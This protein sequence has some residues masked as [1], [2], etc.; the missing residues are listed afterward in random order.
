MIIA[1]D[2]TGDFSKNSNL[3]NI[4]IAVH[5]RSTGTILS[6]IKRRMEKW[7]Q[8]LKQSF[9]N[10]YGEIKSKE[11]DDSELLRISKRIFRSQKVIGITAVGFNAKHNPKELLNKHVQWG[12]GTVAN[13]ILQYK[14]DGNLEMA[15]E[16]GRFAKWAGRLSYAQYAKAI[17]L[18]DC[19][20]H[21]LYNS[22][23]VAAVKKFD[24]ELVDLEWRLDENFIKRKTSKK[25]W[26]E[27]LRNMLR[28]ISSQEPLPILKTWNKKKHP[29]L[30][31]YV[32]EDNN[33]VMGKLFIEKLGFYVS[34]DNFEIRIADIVATI[35]HR[36]FNKKRCQN[37]FNVVNRCNWQPDNQIMSVIKLREI[38]NF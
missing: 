4:F 20:Y 28:Q 32:T 14:R 17:T 3:T 22:V 18:V 16:Y 15:N 6:S 27:L 25:Y 7:E 33:Y 29:F 11:L 13:V 21:S 34:T 5:L 31:K 37:A 19:I 36:Y 12:L 38:K 10:K 8:S 24:K 26:L 35:Y 9:R 1:I 30:K 2:E 23:L